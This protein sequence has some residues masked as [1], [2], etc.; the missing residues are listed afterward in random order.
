M[1][2]ARSLLGV[3]TN[4]RLP[5]E[6]ERRVRSGRDELAWLPDEWL[7]LHS[8]PVGN[9]GSDIDH[10]VIGRAGV[11]SINT[12][13]HKNASIWIASNVFMVN[14]QRQPYL[15]NSRHEAARASR[16]LSAACAMP[17]KVRGVIVVVNADSF[18]I[19]ERPVDVE[20]LY[21]KE[22]FQWLREQSW[23]LD[24]AAVE[25]IFAA[26]RRSST[27]AHPIR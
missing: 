10:L 7:V 27:W 6:W 9:N 11:F 26:A 4:E 21:R 5:G 22:L 14:G 15:R 1:T 18:K 2:L 17:V 19:K 13:H 12:K 16:L 24:R 20:V 8:I 25:R 23:V 3:H